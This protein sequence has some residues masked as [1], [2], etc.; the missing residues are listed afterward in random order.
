MLY[1]NDYNEET[2]VKSQAIAQMVNELNLRWA[3]DAA[4]NPQAKASY[5]SVQEYLAAG[6]RLLLEGIGMQSHYNSRDYTLE[7]VKT[8]LQRYI[9]T[10]ASVS[11]TELDITIEGTNRDTQPSEAQLKTQADNYARLFALYREYADNIR[12]VTFWARDDR[13]SWRAFG[14]GGGTGGY[15]VLFDAGHNPKPAFF[16][17][18]DPYKQ[19]GVAPPA[20]MSADDVAIREAK[21]LLENAFCSMPPIAASNA[22]QAQAAVRAKVAAVAPK[23]VTVAIVDDQLLPGLAGGKDSYVFKLKVA[24]GSGTALTTPVLCAAANIVR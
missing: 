13:S 24:K 10:G 1:Y 4:N 8:A 16:G 6:G 19:L 12:R 14:G 3:K 21:I 18:I 11:V 15:P 5:T 20:P 7:G 23:G 17:V 22:A 9:A 2:V